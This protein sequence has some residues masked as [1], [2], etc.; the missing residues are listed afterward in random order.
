MISREKLL[1]EY[2]SFV[3]KNGKEPIY[4]SATMALKGVNIG[5]SIFKL[6]DEKHPEEDE[7]MLNKIN[8]ID[9]LL[10]YT[11]PDSDYRIIDLL[12]FSDLDDDGIPRE[13]NIVILYDKKTKTLTVK[14]YD[15]SRKYDNVID[16]VEKSRF[17]ININF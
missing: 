4:V 8:G 5:L 10:G 7:A 16:I 14:D 15:P 13:N 3:E 17:K 6:D 11:N 12:A 1:K 2:H 9:D